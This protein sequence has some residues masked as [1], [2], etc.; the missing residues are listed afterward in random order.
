[1]HNLKLRMTGLVL[2][3][4]GLSVVGAAA[5]GDEHEHKFTGPHAKVLE[6]RHELM[7][8]LGTEAKNISDG[9]AM[10]G[11]EMEMIQRSAAVIVGSAAK[12]P[13]VFPKGS[14]SPESRAKPEIW[15][16]WDKFTAL[17]KQL[18][19]N[20]QAVEGAAN[21][22]DNAMIFDLVKTMGGTCKSCHDQFRKPEEKK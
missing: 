14:T 11:V 10:E 19:A 13:D 9:L 4:G 1:M 7:E 12:I 22:D 5:L 2:A 21:S 18:Q 8:G 6:Q 17:A 16:N 15:E 20:A 3:L